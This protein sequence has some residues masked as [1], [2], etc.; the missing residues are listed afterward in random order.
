MADSAWLALIADHKQ[1]QAMQIGQ[2]AAELALKDGLSSVSMSALARAAGVSR[3]TLYNYVPDVATAIRLYLRA[4]GEAFMAYVTSVIAGEKGAEAKLRRYIREQVA[5]VASPE[6]RAAAAL[7][8]AGLGRLSDTPSTHERQAPSLLQEILSEGIE[9][10]V[11]SNHV[12][13]E[14]LALIV[15]RMLYS[16]HALVTTK[17]ISEPSARGALTSLVLDGIRRQDS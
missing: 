16:A 12:G 8:D 7:M 6:H 13:A 17:N 11:F 1:K 9:T 3:A 2:A 5:Y 10:G 4:Q 14:A 15:D